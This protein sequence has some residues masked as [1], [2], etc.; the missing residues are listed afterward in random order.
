MNLD[1]CCVNL[2]PFSS[3]NDFKFE[4]IITLFIFSHFTHTHRGSWLAT[5]FFSAAI[6]FGGWLLNA[7]WKCWVICFG[8]SCFNDTAI[9]INNLIYTLV[10][11]PKM[12]ALNNELLKFCSHSIVGRV[13]IKITTITT[14]FKVAALQLNCQFMSMVL[15]IKY[16][17]ISWK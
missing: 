10:T 16:F 12:P 2:R 17:V 3:S 1:Y 7:E 14:V 4:L 11:P 9:V 13:F 15:D 6:L 5:T 8:Q